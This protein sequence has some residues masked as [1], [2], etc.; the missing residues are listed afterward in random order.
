MSRELTT[1][2][3]WQVLEKNLFAVVGMVTAKSEAR[4]AGVVYVVRERKLY[5]VTGRESWKAK[6]IAQN[7]HVSLTVPIDK[8]I[9]I[10]PWVKIPAATITFCGQAKILPA[11]ETP[12]DLLQALL[13][14]METD[15][16]MVADSCIIEIVPQKDFVTYGVGVSLMTMRNPDKARGRV[17]VNGEALVP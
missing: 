10:A 11:D 4:T 7:P 14:G 9:P 16:E 17:P 8:R 5:V 13:R 15:P 2:D 3:V 12:G 6:H 1:S